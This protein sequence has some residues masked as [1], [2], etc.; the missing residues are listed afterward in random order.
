M[1]IKTKALL[2]AGAVGAAV[3]IRNLKNKQ[4]DRSFV[5][6]IVLITGGS[7]GLGLQLAR[8]FGRRGARLAICARDSAE[9]DRARLDL[10]GRGLE[11]LPVTCDVTQESQVADMVRAVVA[12]YSRIDVLV[13]NAGAIHVGPVESM[14][15][16]DFKTAMDVIFWGTLYPTL[17]VMP[18]YV[19]RQSGKIVNISSIG[20]KV[21]VP[22]LAP[23]SAAKFAVAGLSEGLRSE[24]GKH[25]VTVTAIF[26]GLMR[27]GSSGNAHYRGD[28]ARE[29]GWF[30]T[31]ALLPGFTLS[32][33]RAAQMIADATR[34][35]V[36]ERVLGAPAWTLER[37]HSMFPAKTI[38]LIGTLATAFL[39]I[40]GAQKRLEGTALRKL[41]GP[42]LK[43]LL[44][45]G[46]RTARSLN[47][48]AA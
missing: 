10:E 2:A 12:R 9:L 29:K 45:A 38:E 47:Q 15:A 27:T 21:G 25:N 19:A 7:K 28:A 22:H 4:P 13:N 17:E 3:L 20:G 42:A 31:G 18:S 33:E 1:T 40:L 6:Q 46:Q 48:G 8:E 26:P 5:G 39:P 41:A 30:S 36:G 34:D 16:A 37:V 23:Y 11:V 32:A 24:L 44:W 14:Q 43:M 35:G